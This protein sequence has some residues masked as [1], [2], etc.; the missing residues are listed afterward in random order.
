MRRIFT[1]VSL[2]A[3]VLCSS[4]M[5]LPTTTTPETVTAETHLSYLSDL[6]N[7][8]SDWTLTRESGD[9]STLRGGYLPGLDVVYGAGD[10][11]PVVPLQ[12]LT[13]GGSSGISVGLGNGTYDYA[14]D[15]ST[16]ATVPEPVSILLLGLGLIGTGL[17]GRCKS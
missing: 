14:T 12:N 2:L 13:S 3:L 6:Y 15:Y 7:W 8:N 9:I 17:Y 1:A 5:A 10:L 4:A 11:S 16:G